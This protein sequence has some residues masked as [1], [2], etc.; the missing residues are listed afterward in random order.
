MFDSHCHLTDLNDP[1]QALDQAREAGVHS[2]LTCGYD[3]NSNRKVCELVARHPGLPFALGLHPWFANEPVEPVLALIRRMRPT[4]I[5]EIGLDLLK[6][7]PRQPL[8]RQIQVLQAQLALASELGVAV[9]LHSLKAVDVL[10]GI[11]RQF[12]GVRGVLHA[13]SGSFEQA[14]PFMERGFMIGVGGAIT[15]PKAVRIRKCAEKLPLE[16]IVL[17]TDAP[18]IPM[19]GVAPMHVRPHHL[20]LVRDAL[21]ALQHTSPKQVEKITDK[22]AQTMFSLAPVDESFAKPFL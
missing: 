2:V 20:P 9:T 12:P 8:D 4:A 10:L 3:A 17:E 5:G 19:T 6:K 14:L 16:C 7:P 1:D 13:F 18:A 22:N 15:R 11:V 21:A